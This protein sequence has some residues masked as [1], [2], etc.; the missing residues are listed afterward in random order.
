MQVA[1][2]LQSKYFARAFR[3]VAGV[4]REALRPRR[5][6]W[7]NSHTLFDLVIFRTNDH[8]G[9]CGVLV[10]QSSRFKPST[11]SLS[12]KNHTCIALP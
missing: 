6:W 7:S 10:H 1:H 9:S 4:V 12:R 3:Q 11:L 8:A 5:L 2:S